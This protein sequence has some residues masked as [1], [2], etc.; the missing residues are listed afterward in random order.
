MSWNNEIKIIGRLVR[1]P[2]LRSGDTYKLVKF[3]VAIDRKVKGEDK[4]MFVSCSAWKDV[5]ES[6]LRFIQGDKVKVC[7][8]LDIS[9]YEDKDGVKK[10]F[11]QVVADSVERDAPPPRQPVT[12]GARERGPQ[13]TAVRT[14]A[15]SSDGSLF[16]DEEVPF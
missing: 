12:A 11:T 6:C 4:P 5:A 10:Y 14:A 9:Q 2:E 7:G 8:R 1:D 15:P 3:S 16:D 13:R